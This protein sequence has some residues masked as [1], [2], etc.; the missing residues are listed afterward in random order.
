MGTGT[1][2][3]RTSLTK[4]IFKL[5]KQHKLIEKIAPLL[6]DFFILYGSN[7]PVILAPGNIIGLKAS[8]YKM[9]HSLALGKFTV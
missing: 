3:W 1:P 8:S 7:V 2:I 4:L 5:L 9:I 6:G